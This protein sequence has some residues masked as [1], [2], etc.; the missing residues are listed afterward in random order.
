M[1]GGV[2]MSRSN[3]VILTNPNDKRH[4][5]ALYG[6]HLSQALGANAVLIHIEK[7]KELS[8]LSRLYPEFEE[9]TKELTKLVSDAAKSELEEQKKF[10]SEKGLYVQ[11][12][13]IQAENIEEILESLSKLDPKMIIVPREES[14]ILDFFLGNMVEQMI[15]RS[16]FPVLVH[17]GNEFKSVKKIITPV[18]LQGLSETSLEM[19]IKLAI[20]F[21]SQ[22]DLYHINSD[23]N[24]V[25]S[26]SL[27]DLASDEKEKLRADVLTSKINDPLVK[28]LIKG[29]KV[30]DTESRPK[31][32][33]LNLIEEEVP[34][35]VVMAS[36]GK[37][38]LQ[39]LYL[40]SYCE[41]LVKNTGADILIVKAH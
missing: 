1:R 31:E 41:Y 14:D 10:L 15:R 6:A 7:G 21:K 3:I 36:S 4:R 5:T 38:A 24:K 40:G 18:A 8:L 12:K 26:N 35:L 9:K 37:K 28:D 33:L 17:S 20:A 30:I 32:T 23:Q 11:T 16:P 29:F 25:G 19:S 2:N 39:R 27:L 22:I 13:S 34:D